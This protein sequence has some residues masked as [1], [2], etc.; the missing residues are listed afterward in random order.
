MSKKKQISEVD[1]K[2]L[3]ND[4]AEKLKANNYENEHI[5]NT[6]ANSNNR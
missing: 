4:K 2:E 6:T 5:R 3:V 1:Q